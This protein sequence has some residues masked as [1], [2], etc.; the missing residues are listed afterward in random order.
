MGGF[1]DIS[2]G[3]QGPQVTAVTGKEGQLSCKKQI[4][5]GVTTALT[6]G[7][8]TTGSWEWTYVLHDDREEW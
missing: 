7:H 1:G 2:W 8:G 3:L 6:H 4:W 5:L